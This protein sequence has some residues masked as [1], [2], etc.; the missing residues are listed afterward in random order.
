[1]EI[2]TKND[3]VEYF[4]SGIKQNKLIG[5]ENEQFL[6]NT[7]TNKRAEYKNVKE[8]LQ[9]FI[10]KFGWQEIKEN[11]NLI[12]LNYNGKSISLEPGNQIELSGDKLE[13]IHE[14]CVELHNFQK[15]LDSACFDTNLTNMAT[16]YDPFTKLEDAPNNPKERYKIMTNEM[17]KGG[18]L[19]LNMMYQ[20]SGT[21]VNMDYNSEEDFKKKFKLMSY[22]TPLTI[23]IF[24]NSAVYENKPSGFFS[25]RAKVWQNTARAGLPKLFLESMDFEKYADFIIKF[26][27][28]FI[29]KNNSYHYGENQ[30]FKDFMEGKL[31]S[32]NFLPSSKDLGIHLSTIFTEVRLKK[33]LEARSID[34]CEWDCH[35]AGPAFYTGLVYGNLDESLDIIKKWDQNEVLNAYYDSPKNGL[36]TTIHNKSI[37]DWGKIFLDISGNGLKKRNF[38]NSNDQ[39]ETIF[40]KNINNILK[41]QKTRA[42]KVLE[43]LK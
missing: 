21:Q 8:L 5:V 7:K 39:D 16:G 41:D 29:E 25:Y 35:C 1:M 13:T 9:I 28:L 10:N 22:L 18:E 32:H 4:A 30:T 40:L 17:P 19:S 24:A 20:T 33:Y 2:K 11:Q 14:V 31:K 38:L 43:K 42:E 37:L 36:K 15:E 27:L 26:P 3:I 12:G 34:E 6:F 23:G